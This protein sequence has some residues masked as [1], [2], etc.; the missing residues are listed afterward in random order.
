MTVNEEL[1][2]RAIL[3]AI[4]MERL[5][6]G[7]ARKIL[8]ILSRDTYPKVLA[9]IARLEAVGVERW[10]G[11][12][13]TGNREYREVMDRVD[14]IIQ[15]GIREAGRHLSLD[16][17]S[18]ADLEVAW[19]A[20]A[21]RRAIPISIEIGLPSPG[22]LDAVVKRRPF[23]GRILK[24]WY[25]SLETSAR[26]KVR[27][28]VGRGIAEGESIP[29]IA[30]RIRGTRAKKYTDGVIAAS[31]R[32]V[33][34]VVRTAVNHVTTAAKDATF[35]AN[36]DV[37]KAIQWVSVLDGRTTIQCSSLDGQQFPVDDGPR[38]PIHFACRSSI[39]PIT[40]SFRELGL[41]IDEVPES[42]RSSMDGQVPE[43]TTYGDWLKRQ[44][45]ELQNEVLGKTRAGWF[46]EGRLT[47]D[48]FTDSKQRV[49][50]LPELRDKYGL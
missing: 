4:R 34:S 5:K 43:S 11:I 27:Q 23:Q 41:D 2:D 40:K 6:A 14:A 48:K 45:A 22:L 24:E 29:E 46:R 16:L 13:R 12:I 10:G 17:R 9:Q 38:P 35:Q 30:R 32:E 31:R 36:T 33:E 15:N 1:L 21:L 28:A 3:H 19:Q 37:I 26:A 8:G 20:Q 25:E 47:V 49:L 18:I 42:T 50:T 44:P 39:V 7:Q